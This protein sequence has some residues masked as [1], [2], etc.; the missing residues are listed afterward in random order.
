MYNIQESKRINKLTSKDFII[1]LVIS[2][3][4][5]IIAF[6]NL[7][8][9]KVPQSRIELKKGDTIKIE[10]EKAVNLRNINYYNGCLRE[11][12]Y[13]IKT[14]NKVDYSV[15]ANRTF[16][17]DLWSIREKTKYV[18]I[19]LEDDKG[20]LNELVFL[21]ED[22]NIVIPK[23]VKINN[24]RTHKLSDDIKLYP[25][26]STFK[27]SPYF[28]EYLYVT[29][30]YNYI[31]GGDSYEWTHPPLGKWFISLGIRMF[32]PCPFGWRFVGTVFGIFMLPIIY[33]FARKIF[34]K[35]IYAALACSMFALDFMHFTQS[36]IATIDVY[37]TFFSILMFYF[38]YIYYETSFYDTSLRKTWILLLGSGISMGLAIACKW[39]G[40]YAAIG[41]AIIYFITVIK[42]YK[43]YKYARKDIE[44]ISAGIKHSY[45]VKVYKEYTFKTILFCCVAFLVIPIVI[46]VLSY[47]PVH[48][49]GKENYSLL[50][51]V[52]H[53]QKDIFNYHSALEEGNSNSSKWYTWPLVLKPVLYS[54]EILS[55]THKQG[56]NAM[57]N[58]FIWWVGIIAFI[59]V[60][61]KCI[62]DKDKIALFM[63]IGYIV[64]LLPWAFVS[65]TTFIYHYF[66]CVPFVVLMNIYMFKNINIESIK[67]KRIYIVGYFLL[68]LIAFIMFYPVISGSVINAEYVHTWLRWN[69]NWTLVP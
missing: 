38:M 17:W 28:D 56:I 19:E 30:A 31:Y 61:Y 24:I 69:D 53:N 47:I 68:L 27:D 16:S 1:M 29:T 60:L 58:P 39:T 3:L 35:K 9:I 34:D 22:N 40:C 49:E 51:T 41:I 67:R 52:I 46:Y 14:D 18:Y 55:A 43:E 63:A 62:K 54:T 65:R 44:G 23:K 26:K 4:Y 37:V 12:V 36:R 57:G 20:Q 59:Y 50:Q 64:Q 25:K 2:I 6:F 32:G 42:R 11:C 48:L 21:D 66:T 33:I 13:K 45:I 15:M 10:F 5:S 8:D 7:G